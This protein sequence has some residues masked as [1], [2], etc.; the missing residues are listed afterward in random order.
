VIILFILV[1]NGG[2]IVVVLVVVGIVVGMV[3]AIVGIFTSKKDIWQQKKNSILSIKKK[4]EIKMLL[5]AIQI[6]CK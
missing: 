5:F 4:K 1:V 3:V 6:V 2:T